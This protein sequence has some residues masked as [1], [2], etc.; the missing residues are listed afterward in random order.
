MKPSSSTNNIKSAAVVPLTTPQR[1][2]CDPANGND[3]IVKDASVIMCLTDE[4]TN[5]ILRRGDT[6]EI[7]TL[8]RSLELFIGKR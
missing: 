8:Q 4:E 6:M 2:R 1:I 7:M 5:A 3:I